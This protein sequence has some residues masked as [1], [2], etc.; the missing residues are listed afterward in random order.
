M[1]KITYPGKQGYKKKTNQN[2][3]HKANSRWQGEK[4]S[5]LGTCGEY[6]HPRAESSS[7]EIRE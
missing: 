6:A 2:K 7:A 1:K 3:I 4:P 5:R